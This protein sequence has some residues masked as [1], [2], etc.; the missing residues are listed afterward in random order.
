MAYVRDLVRHELVE[1]SFTGAETPHLDNQ[2]RQAF[3]E[4]DAGDRDYIKF[5]M[6]YKWDNQIVELTHQYLWKNHGYKTKSPPDLSSIYSRNHYLYF[7][8]SDTK[9]F[10][11]SKPLV[12]IVFFEPYKLEAEPV[13]DCRQCSVQRVTRTLSVISSRKLL[14]EAFEE[15]VAN[16]HIGQA[17]PV[18]RMRYYLYCEYIKAKYGPMHKGSRRPIP[19][20]VT[21]LIRNSLPNPPKEK[22]VGYQE[23]YV[24][25]S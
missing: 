24:P 11:D 12:E 20:C 23:S 6:P 14:K 13:T 17:L 2:I 4:F 25:N 9:T 3:V 5:L 18:K 22:Y 10:D 19:H 8:D 21:D 1:L 15:R 7:F 16:A